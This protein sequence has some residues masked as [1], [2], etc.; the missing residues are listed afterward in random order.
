MKNNECTCRKK[1]EQDNKWV[2]KSK[3][4]VSMSFILECV[5]W[6]MQIANN[7]PKAYHQKQRKEMRFLSHLSVWI[8]Y[9]LNAYTMKESFTFRQ[10]VSKHILPLS[11]YTKS[12]ASV[13]VALSP[14]YVATLDK[15]NWRQPQRPTTTTTTKT[16]NSDRNICFPPPVLTE[17]ACVCVF[18][19][20]LKVWLH[21]SEEKLT[22]CVP[23]KWK[24]H[25]LAEKYG[26]GALN[27]YTIFRC[28][29]WM[30]KWFIIE[31]EDCIRQVSS[32]VYLMP[33]S[34]TFGQMKLWWCRSFNVP[35]REIFLYIHWHLVILSARLRAGWS[36]TAFNMCKLLVISNNVKWYDKWA[37]T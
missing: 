5:L 3:S 24:T 4:I 1:N 29:K 23:V 8:L 31:S 32:M 10:N 12:N 22:W 37:L 15:S 21:F 13:V 17:L 20:L 11:K 35:N 27:L 7:L 25:L 9:A 34:D 19:N 36:T 26:I 33:D 16:L 28:W 6:S 14:H 30:I 2:N 18:V